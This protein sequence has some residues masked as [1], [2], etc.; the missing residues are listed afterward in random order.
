MSTIKNNLDKLAATGLPIYISEFEVDISDDN[1]QLKEYQRRFPVLWEHLGVKGITLWGYIQYRI[2]K[3]NGYLIRADGTER[4]ALQWLRSYLAETSVKQ[5]PG[6]EPT[7]YKLYQ[8]YPNPFNPTTTIRYTLSK[9][10]RVKIAVYN[11][12]GLKIRTL[13]DSFQNSGQYS[14]LWDAMDDQSKPV[15]SG[16]YFYRLETPDF[17]MQKKMILVR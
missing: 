5:S 9:S 1:E 12:L 7:D 15:A 11:T 2:W 14:V 13:T 4:P 3:V 17:S 6:S 8:N 16:I 10:S